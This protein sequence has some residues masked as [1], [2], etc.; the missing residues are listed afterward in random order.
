[1]KNRKFIITTLLVLMVSATLLFAASAKDLYSDFSAAVDE[2]AVEEAIS[3][4]AELEEKIESEASA[5]NKSIETAMKKSD[6][7]LYRNAAFELKTLASYRIN[8]EQSDKLLTA[9]LAEDEEKMAEHA[10]WLY[11]NSYSYSPMLTYS[12]S[13]EGENYAF[14]Y[15]S[16]ISAKPGEEVTLPDSGDIRINSTR[17]GQLSGWGLT[18][19]SIDY[20]PGE[21]I[22]MPLT[23]QTLYASW[24][25]AVTFTDERSSTDITHTEVKEGDTIEVP[26]PVADDDAIFDGWYDM[27]SG[28][29][30]APGVSEYTVKGNGAAFE[31]LWEKIEVT[32]LQSGN[33]DTASIPSGVQIPLTFTLSNTGTEDLKD[34]SISVSTTNENVTLLNT[35]AFARGIKGG[36]NVNL[37]GVKLV[38]DKGTASSTEI[39]ITVEIKDGK[40]NTYTSTFTLVTK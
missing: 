1:M 5:A 9:I 32:K 11:E 18:P 14:S 29:Y 19:D 7:A 21:T 30:I 24:Q 33:Y 13:D 15:S 17:F 37:T 20:A 23:S 39:P 25:S 31:A 22:T 28:Q 12:Y 2:G 8:A 3:I 10:T 4:Y 26:Q 36:R 38:V 6:G 40:G 16:S 34:L 35:E 27:T